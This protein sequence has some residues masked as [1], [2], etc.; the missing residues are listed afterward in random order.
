MVQT[1]QNTQSKTRFKKKK[2]RKEQMRNRKIS[3]NGRFK[4][5]HIHNDIKC[6]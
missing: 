5:S 3:Q 1:K 4:S 6:K 2:K